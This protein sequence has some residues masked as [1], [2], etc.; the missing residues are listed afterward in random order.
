MEDQNV[1][2][3]FSN[4]DVAE[5]PLFCCNIFKDSTFSSLSFYI[6]TAR[7]G[8]KEKNEGTQMS[9]IFPSIALTEMDCAIK[10]TFLISSISYY[11]GE[12]RALFFSPLSNTFVY[13][14]RLHVTWEELFPKKFFKCLYLADC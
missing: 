8:D 2:K 7:E 1:K 4:V 3:K 5:L 10:R 13:F 9:C 12:V 11:L 6:E 14:K